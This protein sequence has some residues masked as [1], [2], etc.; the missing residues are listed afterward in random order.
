VTTSGAQAQ[1]DS[2]TDVIVVGAGVA[3]LVAAGQLCDAGLRVLVVEAADAVGGRVR[4]D[5][6]DGFRL[7]RG[8]QVLDT[9]YPEVRR[10]LDLDALRLT[11]FRRG[12][13]VVMRGRRYLVED[14]FAGVVRLRS[15]LT[16][17]IGSLL[18]K[19][20]L[21]LLA[22]ADAVRPVPSANRAAD[23]STADELRRLGFSDQIVEGF[24]RPFL[25][26]VLL[27]TELATSARFFHLLWRSF[28]RGRQA[29]PAFGMHE[30]PVQ[31]ASRL[32]AGALRL[33]A[34]V[35][36][37]DAGGV[38]LDDGER[39]PARAV[40]IATDGGAA[41]DLLPA[42]DRPVWRSVTTIYH[43]VDDPGPLASSGRFIVLDADDPRFIA[44]SCVLSAVSPAYASAGRGL[45]QTSLVGLR[46]DEIEPKVRQ[47]LAVL[48][49]VDTA[50]W[51]H[52]RTYRIADALPEFAPG[53]A[54]R[55]PVRIDGLYVCGDHRDTPSLQGAMVS[56]RR[57]A[58]AVL[59]DLR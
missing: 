53:S 59:A 4:T 10:L 51:R 46:G 42:V 37:V 39:L 16:A 54:M 57:A 58:T 19:T 1:F 3:G 14:P 17:P 34:A 5:V 11:S 45:V 2:P 36:A 27:D 31:L 6:V 56:G 9:A 55:K 28:T 50:R 8:F 44:N 7:D 29:L 32:P 35:R 26:G 30:I 52:L 47:R 40:V 25:S 12:A 13:V 41:H 23:V 43:A 33:S 49:G 18:D 24:F 20:R 38:E 15:T 21:G 22:A 48:Y